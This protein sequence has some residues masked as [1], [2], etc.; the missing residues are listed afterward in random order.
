MEEEPQVGVVE[1]GRVE[2]RQRGVRAFPGLHRG[3]YP[4]VAQRV[5]GTPAQPHEVAWDCGEPALDGLVV[6]LGG[7]Q[8]AA[9]DLAPHVGDD[10]AAPGELGDPGGRDPVDG[11]GG[12]QAVVRRPGRDA[13][14]AIARRKVRSV[15]DAG[16]AFPRELH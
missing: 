10:Q 7:D 12:D 3:K 8:E 1:F 15:A 9:G 14:G 2:R 13:L 16:E 4:A 11:T 6:D 5:V